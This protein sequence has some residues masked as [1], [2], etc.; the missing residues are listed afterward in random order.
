MLS[1]R[2]RFY[3]LAYIVWPVCWF[4]AAALFSA[5]PWFIPL[6][7]AIVIAFV[8]VGL[9]LRCPNCGKPISVNDGGIARPWADRICGRCG[10]DL[11]G[12]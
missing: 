4:G 1:L 11:S 9:A 7:I 8:L 6:M 10:L 5:R 12:K 3:V 2:T